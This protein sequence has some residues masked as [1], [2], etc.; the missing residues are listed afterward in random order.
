MSLRAYRTFTRALVQPPA[1]LGRSPP[2]CDRSL[3]EMIRTTRCPWA[4]ASR[5][6]IP[7]ARQCHVCR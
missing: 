5:A 1:A 6:R 2:L 4:R 3:R 7:T